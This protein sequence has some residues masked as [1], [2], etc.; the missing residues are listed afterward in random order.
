ME[1]LLSAIK[2]MHE[3]NIVHCDIKSQN[4]FMMAPDRLCIGD[5]DWAQI[6]DADDVCK[7]EIGMMMMSFI[8]SCRNKK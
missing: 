2:Y 7:E 5:M 8:C 3:L 1:Q 6:A 4:V